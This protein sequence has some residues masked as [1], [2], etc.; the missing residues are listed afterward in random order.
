MRRSVYKSISVDT[1]KVLGQDASQ[2][3]TSYTS[4]QYVYIYKSHSTHVQSRHAD[5]CKLWIVNLLTIFC[6]E[7][8][9]HLNTLNSV[10]NY[11]L[12]GSG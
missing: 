11:K 5:S 12:L 8:C 3:F 10:D 4:V 1:C 9:T 2:F 6:V 7:L